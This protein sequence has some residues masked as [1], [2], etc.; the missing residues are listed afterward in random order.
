M[1]TAK[2]IFLVSAMVA[3]DKASGGELTPAAA[4]RFA[5]LALACVHRE[6]PN[7]ISHLLNSDADVKPA[8]ELTPA[9]YGCFDWHSSVHGHWLLA[10]LLRLFPDLPEREAICCALETSLSRENIEI[11]A[12]YLLQPGRQSYERT[13]GWAWLLKLDQELGTSGDA[14]A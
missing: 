6:Y 11:E 7:K 12:A 5:N 14:S 2:W 9:F 13:Y 3:M 10:R 1:R 4:D 8:R